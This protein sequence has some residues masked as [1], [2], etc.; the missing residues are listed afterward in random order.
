MQIIVA[1]QPKAGSEFGLVASARTLVKLN[2]ISPAVF[3]LPPALRKPCVEEIDIPSSP[4][5]SAD[6]YGTPLDRDDV[7]AAVPGQRVGISACDSTIDAG[8]VV[9]LG[10]ASGNLY[11]VLSDVLSHFMENQPSSPA[12][13]GFS[14]GTLVDCSHEMPHIYFAE[15]QPLMN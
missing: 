12:V 9:H 4:E 13:N 3:P 2:L 15:E 14:V 5:H 8:D 6:D 1:E 7:A 10:I 11:I